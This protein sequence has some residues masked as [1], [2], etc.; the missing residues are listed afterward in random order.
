MHELA[1]TVSMVVWMQVAAVEGETHLAPELCK[2]LVPQHVSRVNR[3]RSDRNGLDPAV[4]DFPILL[5]IF[6]D[7]PSPVTD[8]DDINQC[9][10]PRQSTN[11]IEHAL[12]VRSCIL[13]SRHAVLLLID[14]E[15]AADRR[16]SWNRVPCLL[17]YG[18][19]AATVP[20][21]LAH[22]RHHN[23]WRAIG[24]LDSTHVFKCT[25]GCIALLANGSIGEY[26]KV[27]ACFA[28]IENNAF[29]V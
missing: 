26:A 17:C 5:Q 13:I 4:P 7:F 21:K 20:N 8:P 25:T 1:M 11:G 28:K 24:S 27:L 23:A 22:I 19:P 14:T 6:H 16:L 29:G 10:L 9:V 2:I 12:N 3:R 18:S 15:W